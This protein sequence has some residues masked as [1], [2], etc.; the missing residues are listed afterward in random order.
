M[1]GDELPDTSALYRQ[2]GNVDQTMN[3][4]F[5]DA[6]IEYL[7]LSQATGLTKIEAYAFASDSN[8]RT[9]KHLNLEGVS[10]SALE[11]SAFNNADLDYLTVDLDLYNNYQFSNMTI[12]TFRIL[13]GKN[14]TEIAVVNA[15]SSNPVINNL[16]IGEGITSIASGINTEV[17]AFSNRG[18]V[19]VNLPSSL[20]Y[21]GRAAFT[22]NNITTLK[23]PSRLKTIGEY[24]FAY[25]KISTDGIY[26]G[27]AS[28]TF[29]NVETIE[30]MAF[31]NNSFVNVY[32]NAG[33][34]EIGESAFIENTSLRYISFNHNADNNTS[35]ND[36]ILISIGK[37]AF[38]GNGITN[39]NF[40]GIKYIG[41]SAFK[42]NNLLASSSWSSGNTIETIEDYAFANNPSFSNAPGGFMFVVGCNIKSI[43]SFAFLN[44]GSQLNLVVPRNSGITFRGETAV[45][46]SE[47]QVSE[48]IKF[49]YDSLRTCS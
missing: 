10:A 17:G 35:T 24:A 19:S 16:I 26:D 3:M 41:N 32:F 31:R 25:N 20:T 23:L 36:E 46:Q 27:V 49:Y 48:G 14:S 5:T 38:Q 8:N 11:G 22:S 29:G 33:V 43:G 42:D 15:G 6:N 47:A 12:D 1:Q 13:K 4:T 30:R 18:I 9:L 34:K 21:I 37:S 40:R 39:A 44:T 28:F 45:S 2:N 7:D